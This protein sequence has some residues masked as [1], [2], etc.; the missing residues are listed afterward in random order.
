M[1]NKKAI[2]GTNF[3][4]PSF[5]FGKRGM[6]DDLFDVLFTV[7]AA[8]FILFFAG[9]ILSGSGAD[10]ERIATGEMGEMTAKENLLIYLKSPVS[11]NRNMADLIV[12]WRY[13][14]EKYNDE[15]ISESFEILKRLPVPQVSSEG[16]NIRIFSS[17][18]VEEIEIAPSS[19]IGGY[20]S[21]NTF[22]SLPLF[23]GDEY[24]KVE[25]HLECQEEACR[26]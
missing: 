1:M 16:W 24:L 5:S 15:L 19:V 3:P 11:N 14:K 4:N 17:D 13:D 7:M 8:F 12:Q 21:W 18:D 25:I 9:L 2:G 10:R 23:E 20:E 26:R 22:V 6:M